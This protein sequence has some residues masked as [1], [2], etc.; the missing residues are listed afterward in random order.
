MSDCLEWAGVKTDQGY[1]QRRLNGKMVYVHRLSYCDSNGLSLDDIKGQVVRHKCDNR[2]CIN[3]D[4]LELGTKQDNSSDMVSRGRQQ[5]GQDHY[6]A[7]LTDDDVRW[8][9]TGGESAQVLADRYGVTR[10][11]IYSVRNRVT[12]KHI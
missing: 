3:P 5:H 6:H 7:K 1:G 10:E 11:A 4:H 12:W 2:S 9:R 8:I